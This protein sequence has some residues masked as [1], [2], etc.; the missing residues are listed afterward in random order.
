[1]K[2]TTSTCVR[3]NI[4]SEIESVTK[5]RSGIKCIDLIRA[6]VSCRPGLSFERLGATAYQAKH[7]K[8]IS[9]SYDST[10]FQVLLAK[11]STPFLGIN[12]R[13]KLLKRAEE[14]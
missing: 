7:G 3:V 8:G 13:T 12:K 6:I 14:S 2:F 1:M 5:S 11:T 4:A 10:H 9:N